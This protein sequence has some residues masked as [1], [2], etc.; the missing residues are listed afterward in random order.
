[1]ALSQLAKDQS[2]QFITESNFT[3]MADQ[4]EF[5]NYD[6]RDECHN[7]DSRAEQLPITKLLAN[8]YLDFK[9]PTTTAASNNPKTKTIFDESANVQTDSAFPE[10]PKAS[11]SNSY[12]D[13]LLPRP[14]K[15]G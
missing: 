1:M 3:N 11:P 9:I 14:H 2:D 4:V 13:K 15:S 6:F 8:I 7:I 12:K 5:I 10:I